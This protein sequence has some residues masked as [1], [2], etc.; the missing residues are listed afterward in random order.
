MTTLAFLH[1]PIMLRLGLFNSKLKTT[2]PYR[3]NKN[4]FHCV[5]SLLIKFIV[6]IIPLFFSNCKP[7]P[8]INSQ[9]TVHIDRVKGKYTLYWHGKPFV[10]K[11]AAGY[12]NLKKLKEAGGNTIRTWDTTNLEAILKEADLN[13]LAVIVGLP[14]PYS[15]NPFTDKLDLF[16]T[17]SAQLTKMFNS[18]TSLVEKYRNHPSILF[19][20][21]GNELD[22]PYK[23]NYNPFYTAINHIVDV[24]HTIDPNHPVTTTIINFQRRNIINIK[25]KTKIDV[26]SFNVFGDIRSLNKELKDFEWF[27]DGPFLITEWGNDGP[28]ADHEHTLWGAYIEPTSTKKA[29]QNL[30]I[31]KQFMPVNNPNFLGSLVFYWGHKQEYTSTWFSL[32]DENGA[33]SETVGTMQYIWTSKWPQHA[34]PQINYVLVND[35]GARDNILFKPDTITYARLYMAN[36]DTVGLSYKWQIKPEDWYKTS[37]D[38][39]QNKQKT[40]EHL[41]ISQKN[42]TVSFRTPLKEGPYRLFVTVY[43]RFGNFS[44]ANVPFYVVDNR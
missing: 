24:I 38:A 32:F 2:V 29:E 37:R 20:C 35:K 22:F 34:A 13:H 39:N 21:I 27:W 8:V 6:L 44:T 28:W 14:M 4:R 15:K 7:K 36:A 17:N 5:Q 26:I 18:Y 30:A 3:F 10:I 19:W 12:T 42:T 1:Q 25:F 40:V 9:R 41:F 31:H 33:A 43:D 16:Y 23:P 11:G